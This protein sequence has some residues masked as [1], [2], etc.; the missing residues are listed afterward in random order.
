MDATLLLSQLTSLHCLTQ[1]TLETLT[2][3]FKLFGITEEGLTKGLDLVETAANAIKNLQSL[4]IVTTTIRPES[5]HGGLEFEDQTRKSTATGLVALEYTDVIDEESKVMVKTELPEQQEDATLPV[6]HGELFNHLDNE[7][8]ID[9]GMLTSS[10]GESSNHQSTSED[11][12]N[13]SQ[14]TVSLALDYQKIIP[15][16]LTSSAMTETLSATTDSHLSANGSHTLFVD[17]SYQPSSREDGANATVSSASDLDIIPSNLTTSTMTDSHPL[18]KVGHALSMDHSNQPPTPIEDQA[19]SSQ[20]VSLASDNGDISPSSHPTASSKTD[21][22]PAMIYDERAA[23]DTPF[24]EPSGRFNYC[25]YCEEK[26]RYIKRHCER[27]HCD[28]LL[29]AEAISS[30]S[31]NPLHAAYIWEQ[32]R[33]RGNF[34]HNQA[35]HNGI[36]TDLIVKKTCAKGDKIPIDEFVPCEYC[37]AYVKA[38]SLQEHKRKCKST[39]SDGPARSRSLPGTKR[40][41]PKNT[42]SRSSE[43]IKALKSSTQSSRIPCK[44]SE[45][46]KDYECKALGQ[47][48]SPKRI[49][50]VRGSIVPLQ[51]TNRGGISRSKSLPETKRRPPKNKR[52]SERLKK[53][54]ASATSTQSALIPCKLFESVKAKKSQMYCLYCEKPLTAIKDHC[55]RKH[56]SEALVVEAMSSMKTNPSH[57]WLIWDLIKHKGNFRHY[58]AVR[59]GVKTV[60]V[61]KENPEKGKVPITD[62]VPCVADPKHT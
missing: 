41:P 49:R 37:F 44:S 15:C 62:I 21:H 28:E 5:Y 38:A 34:L 54:R 11:Q 12:A 2:H 4:F 31:T 39:T 57:S 14:T 61:V 27:K 20:T 6:E 58:Q 3:Q 32:I 26:Q 53:L 52:S 8:G 22:P 16:N 48:T 46:L 55:E 33:K 25:L 47:E 10:V 23:N 24:V 43:R 42:C 51:K 50:R 56:S 7:E 9:E 18:A 1:E 36:K 59:F 60:L 40:K 29:V 13:S 19:N 17:T 35:V 45:S 30:K